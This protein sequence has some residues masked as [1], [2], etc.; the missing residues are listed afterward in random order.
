MEQGLPTVI[1]QLTVIIVAARVVSAL[2]RKA[3]QPGVC[4]EMA[5]GLILGPSLFGKFFPHLFRSIFDPSVAHT[6]TIL[7]Q[8]GLVLLLFLIGMEFDFSLLR[9]HGRRAIG[10]SVAGTLELLFFGLFLL[11]PVVPLSLANSTLLPIR[12]FFPLPPHL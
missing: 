11:P 5:A 1:L 7:S 3:G 8:I 2:F 6:I 10:I 9:T 12:L 4:G